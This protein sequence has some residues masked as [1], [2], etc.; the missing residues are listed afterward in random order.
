[1]AED[2]VALLRHLGIEQVDVFGYSFGSEIAMNI[3]YRHPQ[4]VRKLVL[5]GGT[6][7]NEEGLHP[8][9]MDQVGSIPPEAFEGTPWKEAY[10]KVAP[11]PVDWAALVAKKKAKSKRV[12][13]PGFSVDFRF[14]T[15]PRIFPDK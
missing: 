11:N 10:D 7:Y 8:G 4:M 5:A 15:S 12:I 2:T 9:M 13:S 1:M 14:A 6:S 3:A